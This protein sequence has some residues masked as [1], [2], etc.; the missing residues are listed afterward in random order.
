MSAAR[1]GPSTSRGDR[2]PLRAAA[3][4]R[5][6]RRGSG[7]I[8]LPRDPRHSRDYEVVGTELFQVPDN[9]I[10]HRPADTHLLLATLFQGQPQVFVVFDSRSSRRHFTSATEQ[11]PATSEKGPCDPAISL[12]PEHLQSCSHSS[13]LPNK[14]RRGPGGLQNQRPLESAQKQKNRRSCGGSSF[15]HFLKSAFSTRRQADSGLSA[16]APFDNRSR[17][18]HLRSGKQLGVCVSENSAVPIDLRSSRSS[19]TE[20]R[21]PVG[22]SRKLEVNERTCPG[23]PPSR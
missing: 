11:R 2:L 17:L 10:G 22:P 7:G 15:Q 14:N 16:M 3:C 12:F 21:A 6:Q 20:C 18:L 8:R 9:L 5:R 4:G 19:R 1:R 23:S 13:V